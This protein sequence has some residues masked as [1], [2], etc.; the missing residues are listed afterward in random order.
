MSQRLRARTHAYAHT[1]THTH[2]LFFP[3][4]ERALGAALVTQDKQGS[5]RTARTQDRPS[6]SQKSS[7]STSTST[8]EVT[9]HQRRKQ[10]LCVQKRHH[11]HAPEVPS[12]DPR[13]AHHSVPQNAT[14]KQQHGPPKSRQPLPRNVPPRPCQTAKLNVEETARNPPRKQ[15]RQPASLQQNSSRAVYITTIKVR[16]QIPKSAPMPTNRATRL[17]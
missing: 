16:S 14:T 8:T 4:V 5:M 9:P 17:T 15:Q 7:T 3:N 2:R 10:P 11:Q 13:K 6:A 1:R 12:S